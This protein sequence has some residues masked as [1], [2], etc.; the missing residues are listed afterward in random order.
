MEASW[1]LLSIPLPATKAAPPL[2]NWM[3][4]GEPFFL[5]ASRAALTVLNFKLFIVSLM[6]HKR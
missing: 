5:A 1:F 2:E 6:S 3:M 4:M